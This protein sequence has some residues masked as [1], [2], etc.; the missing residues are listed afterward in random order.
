MRA[1]DAVVAMKDVVVA[2]KDVVVANI[3]SI[4]QDVFLSYSL[5]HVATSNDAHAAKMMW[6]GGND[7]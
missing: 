6:C 2:M 4:Q 3:V 5:T 1:L 7:S